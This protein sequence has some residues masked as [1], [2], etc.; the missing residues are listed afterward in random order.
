MGCLGWLSAAGTDQSRVETWANHLQRDGQMAEC[1][2]DS[3]PLESRLA[4]NLAA[5]TASVLVE[6]ILF[7]LTHDPID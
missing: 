6:T 3:R 4:V 7:D 5:S 1:W 2:D